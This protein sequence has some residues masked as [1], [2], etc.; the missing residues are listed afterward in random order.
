MAD[1]ERLRPVPFRTRRQSVADM[2]GQ[3][4]KH[5]MPILLRANHDVVA[6]QSVHV[7]QRRIRDAEACVHHQLDHFFEVFAGPRAR[8]L[9]VL[10]L[11]ADVA[12]TAL[13]LMHR[14]VSVVARLPD[15]VQLL[16]VERHLVGAYWNR[17][18]LMS[19][20]IGV[21]DIHFRLTAKRK[22]ARRTPRRV[23]FVRA[24]SFSPA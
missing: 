16:V 20:L 14:T 4:G 11:A 24:P 23:P 6:L 8:S 12:W 3:P 17:R 9:S 15:A 13:S 7:E 22:N 5:M 19:E 10:V 2:I 1:D 21:S 18:S